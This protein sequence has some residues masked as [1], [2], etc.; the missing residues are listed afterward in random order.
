MEIKESWSSSTHIRQNRFQNKECY[1]RQRRILY[2]DQKINP[3]RRYNNCIYVYVCMQHRNTSVSKANTT[4][5]KGKINRNT[6]IWGDFN[7]SLLSRNRS[8]T[9]KIR[10]HRPYMTH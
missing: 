2:N 6:I 9:Q 4:S 7:N 3:R 1:K 10:K 8:C 5:C